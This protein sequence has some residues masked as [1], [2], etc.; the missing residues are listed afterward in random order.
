MSNFRI[1]RWNDRQVIEILQKLA[2]E[3]TIQKPELHFVAFEG[4]G[5][6]Y[7]SFDQISTNKILNEFLPQDTALTKS[8]GLYGQVSGQKRPFVVVTRDRPNLFDSLQFHYQPEFDQTQS[9]KLM[10]LAKKEFKEIQVDTA[11]SAL[12]PNEL[13]SYFEA[14]EATLSR[15]EVMSRDLVYGAHE[16][17]KELDQQ[18]QKRFE[19]LGAKLASDRGALRIEFEKKEAVVAEREKA[20]KDKEAEFETRESK[21]LRRQLRKDMLDKLRRLGEKFSLTTGTK[22]LRWPIHVFV[23]IILIF[24]GS[25]TILNFQQAVSLLN[26]AGQ[27]WSRLHWWQFALLGFKQIGFAAAFLAAAW[28]YVKWNDDWFRKHADAE[29]MFTQMELD[30][31]RASWVVEMALEWK[32]EK[33]EA[34]PRELLEPLSRNLFQYTGASRDVTETPANLASMILG[35]AYSAKIQTPTGE[36]QFDKKS[37]SKVAKQIEED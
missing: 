25:M 2:S 6:T 7:I 5:G 28:Y 8:F 34:L 10:A 29:F 3:V 33:G 21:Y 32:T 27:D 31:N 1:P 12:G 14:R 20:I 18:Y 36:L 37:L 15:L 30:I 35:A 4:Q 19:E 26:A 22:R 24:C 16:R 17:Q 9:A 11:L 23:A 13:Q